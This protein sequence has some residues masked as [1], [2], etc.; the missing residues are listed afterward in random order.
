[1]TLGDYIGRKVRVEGTY[2]GK[3]NRYSSRYAVALEDVRILDLQGNEIEWNKDH[4][5][6][7]KAWEIEKIKELAVGDKVS[8]IATARS[9]RNKDGRAGI[10]FT[11][12][13]A[14][15]WQSFV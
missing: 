6:L 10:C 3:D 1:M 7:Q 4:T 5:W 8:C 14:I 2:N 12:P 13:S 11:D 15:E 9:Y